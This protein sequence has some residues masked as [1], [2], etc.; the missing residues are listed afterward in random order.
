M[1]SALHP[2]FGMERSSWSSILAAEPGAVVVDSCN[3]V[4]PA[5]MCLPGR[6]TRSWDGSADGANMNISLSLPMS[7]SGMVA[8]GVAVSS[9]HLFT[10]NYGSCA[11]LCDSES[12]IC[13]TFMVRWNTGTD[14][15]ETPLHANG[16]VFSYGS[17]MLTPYADIHVSER[18][19][20]AK[21]AACT[22]I[23]M[24][25]ACRVQLAVKSSWSFLCTQG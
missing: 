23:C 11:L 12:F 25:P 9:L 14:D 24:W 21:L 15:T 13:D 2:N 5:H 8:G 22:F 7:Y 1:L 18:Q 3:D 6:Q 4:L 10:Y 20:H 16:Q 17:L 19:L